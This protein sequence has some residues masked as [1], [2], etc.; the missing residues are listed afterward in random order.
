M[1]SAGGDGGRDS[2]LFSA[3]GV[4]NV[5][6][7]YSVQYDWVAKIR[8]TVVRLQET[9][10]AAN[11]LVFISNQLIGAKA[12]DLKSELSKKGIHLD[13]RDKSWFVERCNLD[14]SRSS[15]AAE[16][17][18]VIVDPLLEASAVKHSTASPL[19]DVYLVTAKHVL[20]GW[21]AQRVSQ[22]QRDAMRATL[23]VGDAAMHRGHLPEDDDLRLALDI[24]EGVFAPIFAHKDKAKKLSDAVP[25][26]KRPP[27]AAVN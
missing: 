17:A 13:V 4:P 12:D 20:E 18:R 11:V 26:R 1:A 24:I 19:Y 9:F 27:P 14:E 7:Q 25:P 5:V 21:K 16:L 22:I 23:D 6:I 8:A 10:P 3:E 2:E 15:A